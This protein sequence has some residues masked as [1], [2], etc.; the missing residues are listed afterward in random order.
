L[1]QRSSEL[2]PEPLG[3]QTTMQEPASKSA[4]TVSRA[5][6]APYQRLT[7]PAGEE[8]AREADHEID[9]RREEIE[10]D[11][12]H[13]ALG[14]QKGRMQ[15]FAHAHD[16]GDRRALEHDHALRHQRRRH[17]AQRL[18]QHHEAHRL[19]IAQPG[20]HRRLELAAAHRLDARAHDLGE[21]GGEEDG[22]GEQHGHEVADRTA[23]HD[24]DQE[25]EPEDD[26]DQRIAA[27]RVDQQHRGIAQPSPAAEPAQRHEAAEREAERDRDQRQLDAVP[28]SAHQE[29]QVV[30]DHRPVEAHA[31]HRRAIRPGM[32]IRRSS[33]PMKTTTKAVVVMYVADA[34]VKASIPRNDQD[35]IERAA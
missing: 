32:R 16:I 35:S 19:A 34:T 4:E 9:R 10:L 21:I 14:D 31:A 27:Q 33:Q 18:G 28:Q 6:K 5:R 20:G 24:R 15:E 29:G 8:R 2:L 30:G 1:T 25:E 7:S 26:Q 22:E 13:R 17:A 3:P 23:G 12:T 11:G